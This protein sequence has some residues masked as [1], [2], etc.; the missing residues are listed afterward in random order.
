MSQ[1]PLEMAEGQDDRMPWKNLQV[2]G[3]DIWRLRRDEGKQPSLKSGGNNSSNARVEAPSG[4]Q[5]EW[6]EAW[7][8]EAKTDLNAEKRSIEGDDQ[9]NS[10]IGEPGRV[11]W[12]DENVSVA[13]NGVNVAEIMFDD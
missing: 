6:H 11:P 5:T 9:D 2:Q 8:W 4:S 7:E 12:E 13:D 1:F 3:I 10:E